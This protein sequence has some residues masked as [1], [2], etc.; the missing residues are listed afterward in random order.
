MRFWLFSLMIFLRSLQTSG[1]LADLESD[2][3]HSSECCADPAPEKGG[4]VLM[5]ITGEERIIM[6]DLGRSEEYLSSPVPANTRAQSFDPSIPLLH[7]QSQT[8]TRTTLL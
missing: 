1:W 3:T 6:S 8:V 5:I 2:K 7:N 4:L